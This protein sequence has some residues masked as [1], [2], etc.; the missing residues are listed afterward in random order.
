MLAIP[1]MLIEEAE[2]GESL[3]PHWP[4]SLAQLGEALGQE[5]TLT[6]TDI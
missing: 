5:E 4:S 3:A 6:Q 1:A 2:T